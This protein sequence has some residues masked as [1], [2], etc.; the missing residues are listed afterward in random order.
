MTTHPNHLDSFLLIQRRGGFPSKAFLD[1]ASHLLNEEK[2]RSP[3]SMETDTGVG[4]C[5]KK[6]SN[7]SIWFQVVLY[8]PWL[9]CCVVLINKI[10]RG[11]ATASSYNTS[12][13]IKHLKHE[14]LKCLQTNYLF[15]YLFTSVRKVLFSLLLQG[16]E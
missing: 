3:A 9:V 2:P 14:A 11:R 6:C 7:T 15:I 4:F 13:L 1:G 16:M 12:N 10:S 5:T 8:S